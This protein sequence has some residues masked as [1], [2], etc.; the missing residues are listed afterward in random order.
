MKIEGALFAIGTIFYGVIAIVYWF[1]TNETVGTTTLALTGGLSF[2]VGFYV[3]FAC[4]VTVSVQLVGVYLVF[5]TLIVPAVAVYRFPA[6]QQLLLGM[7]LAAVSYAAGLALSAVTDM[8]ASPVVVWA[9][10]M[11]GIVL[12]LASPRQAAASPHQA[13]APSQHEGPRA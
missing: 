8:P 5:T 6:Q 9:M 7:L 4:V 3:L 2:L 12:H 10:V 11:I 13:A 1:I